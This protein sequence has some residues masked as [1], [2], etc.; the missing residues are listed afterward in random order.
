METVS[1]IL[2]STKK[3]VFG[4]VVSI[5]REKDTTMKLC[6]YKNLFT[7]NNN[8]IKQSYLQAFFAKKDR[9]DTK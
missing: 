4:K 5:E 3:K 7:M 8:D 1:N 2:F 9:G 6:L